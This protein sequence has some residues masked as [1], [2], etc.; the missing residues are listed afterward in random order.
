MANCLIS[1]L[2]ALLPTPSSIIKIF[3]HWVYLPWSDFKIIFS[4]IKIDLLLFFTCFYYWLL[5]FSQKIVNCKYFGMVWNAA[6]NAPSCVKFWCIRRD[7]QTY[8]C[9]WSFS[10]PGRHAYD[11]FE[12][13]DKFKIFKSFLRRIYRK[14][15][16]YTQNSTV[17][18]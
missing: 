12:I 11:I 13:Y 9:L 6:I 4:S 3:K 18:R 5:P 16:Q 17:F 7:D 2:P 10:Y 1:L 8:D 15:L 14:N